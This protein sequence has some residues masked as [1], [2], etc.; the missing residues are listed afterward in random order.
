MVAKASKDLDTHVG[1]DVIGYVITISL[2]IYGNPCA[3]GLA[4]VL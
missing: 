1:H 4:G 2:V 3:T